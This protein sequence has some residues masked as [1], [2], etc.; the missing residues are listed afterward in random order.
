MASRTNANDDV[1]SVTGAASSW[2]ILVAKTNPP[3]F[4]FDDVLVAPDLGRVC[5]IHIHVWHS[6]TRHAI[7][8]VQQR[9]VFSGNT[10]AREQSDG[11]PV[12]V[13]DP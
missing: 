13:S 9:L 2:H 5:Q 11:F 8:K 4:Q 7:S 6:T 3:T 12:S 10:A 1:A